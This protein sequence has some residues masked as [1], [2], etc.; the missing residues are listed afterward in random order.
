[1]LTLCKRNFTNTNVNTYIYKCRL[2]N[3]RCKFTYANICIFIRRAEGWGGGGAWQAGR[4]RAAEGCR[5]SRG[6]PGGTEGCC[7]AGNSEC[8]GSRQGQACALKG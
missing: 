3:H 4:Q 6:K 2:Y 5:D 7:A 8:R 1:M